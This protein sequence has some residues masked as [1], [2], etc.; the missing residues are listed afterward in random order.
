MTFTGI[1][2]HIAERFRE[3]DE[4]N[5]HV[6]QAVLR[7]ANEAK[8]SGRKRFGIKVIWERMRWYLSFETTEKPI[9]LNNNYTS[10]YA[11]KLIATD[12]TFASMLEVRTTRG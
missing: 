4:A 7:F 2:P 8:A 9:K 5:P 11:R 1:K 10:C 6:W 12:P 3:F